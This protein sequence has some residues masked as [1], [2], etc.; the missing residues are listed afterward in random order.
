MSDEAT[1]AVQ[2]PQDS[3][4]KAIPELPAETPTEPTTTEPDK[5]SG[6]SRDDII[7]SYSEL[8]KRFGQ[9]GG[10]LGQ[11]R[12]VTDDYIKSSE[13]I[14]NV[15]PPP[16]YAPQQQPQQQPIEEES[17]DY[18]S[19]PEKAVQSQINKAL[20]P[21][22]AELGSLRAEKMGAKLQQA[23]PD[24]MDVVQNTEF[25]QWVTQSPM[26]VEMLARA[27]RQ[28][29]YNS[30]DELFSTWKVVR[31]AQAPTTP[32]D[33]E[34]R[35]ASLE[36]SNAVQDEEAPKKLYRRADIVELKTKNPARYQALA[37]EIQQAYVEGRVR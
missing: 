14:N 32:S 2:P 17:F 15:A 25:Q 5:F 6:K 27:D 1:Q 28:Y 4:D 36:I 3:L 35:N 29:D 20:G 37:E 13:A 9:Q 31:G 10:E 30:A 24:Y 7:N 21:M 19:E 11:L 16:T 26:R 18:I 22:Q 23:H 33:E 34:F 12:K 8:E